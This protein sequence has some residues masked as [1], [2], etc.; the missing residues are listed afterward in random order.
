MAETLGALAAGIGILT[1][2]AGVVRWVYRRFR[3]WRAQ[4]TP[5][6]PIYPVRLT[7]REANDFHPSS[8]Y[9]EGLHFEVFNESERTVILRGFGLDIE[10][11]G[12]AVWHDY[13]FTHQYPADAFPLRL[14]PHEGVDGYID[15]EAL[16]DEIYARGESSFLIGWSPYVEVVGH[17]QAVAEIEPDSGR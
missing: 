2:I 12:P 17:G 4:R 6:Q 11:R 7:C 10:M 1:G 3:K 15:I 5:A 14:K 8:G 13:Q 9:H 16:R